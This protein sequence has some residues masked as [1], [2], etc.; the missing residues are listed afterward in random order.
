MLDSPRP[1]TSSGASILTQGDLEQVTTLNIQDMEYS[2]DELEQIQKAFLLIKNKR[3]ETK[4]TK[5]E[6]AKTPAESKPQEPKTPKTPAEKKSEGKG[7]K[8]KKTAKGRGKG[9]KKK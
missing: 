4:E 8:K 3:S 5:A 9:I 6:E 2:A 1:S 7:P